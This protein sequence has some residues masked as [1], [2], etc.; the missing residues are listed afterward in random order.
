MTGAWVAVGD[1]VVVEVAVGMEVRVGRGVA[2]G[3][4]VRVGGG[5]GVAVRGM[6][7]A[8]GLSLWVGSGLA[9]REESAGSVEIPAKDG[10]L[11]VTG[12]T[13]QD[14]QVSEAASKNKRATM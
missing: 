2:V 5:S 12:R 4:G 11:S 7:V 6:G 10:P 8:L 1:G 3:S 14:I 13:W 9:A